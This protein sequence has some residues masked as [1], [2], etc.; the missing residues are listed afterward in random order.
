[1]FLSS[2][3]SFLHR[4]ECSFVHELA[5]T[6]RQNLT[7]E[8]CGVQDTIEVLKFLNLKIEFFSSNQCSSHGSL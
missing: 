2:F 5:Q 3:S 4:I 1:M 8:A 6:F 7:Q